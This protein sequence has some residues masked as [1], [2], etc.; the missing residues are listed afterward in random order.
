MTAKKT[1]STKEVLQ[2]DPVNEFWGK[3]QAYVN[4]NRQKLIAIGVTLCVVVGAVVIWKNVRETA[5]QESLTLLHTNMQLLETPS[6]KEAVDLKARYGQARQGFEKVL[7]QYS[8]T[9]AATTALLFAGD[10]CFKLEQYDDAI[11][12]YTDFVDK[13]G[14]ALSHLVPAAYSSIGYAHEAKGE[15]A[16]AVTLFEK[17]K[18]ALGDTGA[19]AALLNIGRCYEAAGNREKACQAYR[20]Y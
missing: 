14:S 10:S 5:R 4:E 2:S 17:Q 3:V 19:S 13:A 9:P 8:G 11:S 7:Q 18:A 6:V 16:E 20:E 15:Y 12:Y 1:M